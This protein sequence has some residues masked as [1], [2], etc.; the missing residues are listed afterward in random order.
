MNNLLFDK[1][2]APNAKYIYNI[3]KKFAFKDM[4][5]DETY[6]NALIYVYNAIGTYKGQNSHSLKAWLAT[7]TKHSIYRQRAKQQRYNNRFEICEDFEKFSFICDNYNSPKNWKIMAFSDR[8]ICFFKIIPLSYK[9]TLIYHLQ[10]YSYKETAKFQG[11][12]PHTIHRRLNTIRR[13]WKLST[14]E[15]KLIWHNNH[16]TP[17]KLPT[18]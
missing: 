14:A 8:F 17:Y 2:I 1:H 7:C 6:N 11:L 9:K 4:N 5:I 18:T 12:S 16:H 13:L 10:G 15:N 3:C